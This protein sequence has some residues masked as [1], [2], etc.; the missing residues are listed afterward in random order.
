MGGTRVRQ[1]DHPLVHHKLASLRARETTPQQFRAIME[2]ISLLMAWEVTRDLPLREATVET[3]LESARVQVLAERKL[4]LIPILRAGLG[5]LPGMLRLMPEAAVGH[6]GVYRDH[7]TLE[8]VQYYCELPADIA[9]RHAVILDP[10]LATGGSAAA[11]IRLLKERGA[12]SVKLVSLIAAPE[13]ISRV[14]A[15]HPDV[16][17]LVAAVDR[18]LDARAYIRPGLG[19]AG[20]RLFG[21][22]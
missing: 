15:A 5:M 16:E 22:R 20:D 19:D 14:G 13:G 8:P 12:P 2:D 7:D 10:M 6:V 1:V 21:T 18:E 11:A 4:A 9:E 3:P 17:I